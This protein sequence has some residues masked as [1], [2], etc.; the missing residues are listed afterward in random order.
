MSEALVTIVVSAGGASERMLRTC[1]CSLERHQGTTES[2]VMVVAP[3]LQAGIPA[4][5]CEELKVPFKHFEVQTD[6]M[7]GSRAHAAVLDMALFHV[8]TPYVLTLDADCFP[9]ADDWLDALMAPM[10]AGADVTG[11]LHPYAPPPLSLESH[12]I[13]HRIRSQLCW[14]NTHV[15]CQLVG[16]KTLTKRL[17][18]GFMDGDDTGLAIPMKAH[19]MGMKVE[20]L[21]LTGCARPADE[22]EPLEFNRECC[23]IFGDKVYHHGGGS[24]EEQGKGSPEDIWRKVR[25]KVLKEGGAEF[26]LEDP[27]RYKFD[28][29]EDVAYEMVGRIMQ[30]M[31]IYLQSHDRV[32]AE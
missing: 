27:Y 22:D 1:L 13:E 15:A 12:T 6:H 2:T 19:E 11:I 17:R 10:G 28:C 31:Q 4:H 30:G 5:V 3:W 32:F 16:M 21:K 8:R 24:R 26:L 25:F 29:E 23:L 7:S 9:I 14:N 20:G 18:V